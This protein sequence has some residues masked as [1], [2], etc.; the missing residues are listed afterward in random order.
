MD[1]VAEPPDNN[2]FNLLGQEE[3]SPITSLGMPH[4]KKNQY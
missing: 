4:D 2:L 1:V 3:T